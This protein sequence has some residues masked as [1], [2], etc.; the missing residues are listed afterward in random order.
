MITYWI[1]VCPKIKDFRK[2]N[3]MINGDDI[4]FKC[5]KVEYQNWL[6]LLPEA[7]L[8][9]SPGKNFLH[10]K[11]GTVNSALF[12]QESSK[13]TKY[14]PFFNVGMLLGQSK[15]ASDKEG[16]NKPVHCLH[17]SALHGAINPIRAD[18]RFRFYKKEK[19]IKSSKMY[20]GT[21]LNWYLPRTMGG[22]GMKLPDGVEFKGEHDKPKKGNFVLVTDRQRIIAYGLRKA[23][24]ADDLLKAPFQ[25]IGMEKDEDLENWGDIRKKVYLKA[26]LSDCPMLPD[27]EEF[28]S[29]HHDP[30]WYI[31]YTGKIEKECLKYLFK[32][33][34][35]KRFAVPCE[36][37][38]HSTYYREG[39]LYNRVVEG[40][41]KY[42]LISLDNVH[43]YQELKI[44]KK[45]KDR[46]GLTYIQSQEEI[47]FEE[48]MRSFDLTVPDDD[49]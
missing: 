28:D 30:N 20:D 26:Q 41:K 42:N 48:F 17:Q 34:Y 33:L 4:M 10:C 35:F 16:C 32:G 15:V 47:L 9:P 25:P 24:Y 27:C 18:L 22:L 21:Q 38:E 19:L 43:L 8:T 45:R 49:Y 7:G 12:Y 37:G 2:L 14:I 36:S 29:E 6:N 44:F 5:N 46:R 40:N 3:V 31:P 1:A 23:W 11:Y 39:K 13:V